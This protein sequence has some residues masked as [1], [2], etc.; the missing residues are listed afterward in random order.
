MTK[1]KLYHTAVYTYNI[2]LYHS[3]LARLYYTIPSI[4]YYTYTNMQTCPKT[5]S[6]KIQH[7]LEYTIK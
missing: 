5:Q 3:Y 6:T 2:L 4:Q 1:Q 7:L